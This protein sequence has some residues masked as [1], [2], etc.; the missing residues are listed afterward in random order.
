MGITAGSVPPQPVTG[1]GA[2]RS[3]A[4]DASLDHDL[5]IRTRPVRAAQRVN[6]QRA[7]ADLDAVADVFA[8]RL[9]AANLGPEIDRVRARAL[10]LAAAGGEV[11]PA[12]ALAFASDVF[13]I[14]AVE[15]SWNPRHAERLVSRLSSLLALPRDSVS[16]QLFLGAVGSPQFLDLPPTVALEAQLRLVVALA[17]VVEGS[18]WTRA[19][20]GRPVCLVATGRKTETRRFRA[21]A[22]R[23]LDG[24]FAD[25]GSRGAIVGAPVM[26]WETPWAALVVRAPFDKREVAGA[27]LA[28]AASAMSPVVERELLLQ[29]S[30]DR[31]RSLVRASE[32]RLG[33][34]AFDLHDGALQHVAAL[35][36]DL[37]LFRSQLAEVDGGASEPVMIGRLDDLEARVWE[38]DRVLR[39]LAH[40]LEPRSLVRRP[41]PHVISDEVAAFVDRT[42]IEVEQHVVGEF[43]G[44]SA[45]Q[46]I[47]LIRVV[48]EALTNVREHANAAHVR[49]EISARNSRVDARVEDDGI[50]FRVARTLLDSAQRG[51]LGLV[52]SSERIRLLGGTFD[53]RSRAGGPTTISLSLPRWQP[54]GIEHQREGTDS[55]MLAMD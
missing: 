19:A 32:R 36:T 11:S 3:G 44:L 16:L 45:S 27:Y 15:R 50:G 47:A 48:Q 22:S 9:E 31:E 1:R 5:V 42:G 10:K 41:L 12:I 4:E 23:A 17:P 34:L 54:L 55:P 8:S 52:G 39:E 38:L 13:A 33:R 18:L 35:G 25:S 49:I 20:D 37:Y 40:S 21:V 30:A 14:C 26:R 7:P 28:E 43:G 24:N 51:R 29:R 6:G 53:V 2:R 46:K